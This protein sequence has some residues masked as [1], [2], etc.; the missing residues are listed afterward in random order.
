MEC[1][2]SASRGV[3]G[4]CRTALFLLCFVIVSEAVGGVQNCLVPLNEVNEP[5][6][7]TVTVR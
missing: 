7:V 5:G 1:E 4:R 3:G 6:G 2:C